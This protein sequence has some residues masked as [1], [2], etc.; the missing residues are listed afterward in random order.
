M[1]FLLAVVVLTALSPSRAATAQDAA[2]PLEIVEVIEVPGVGAED[3]FTRAETW[4]AETFVNSTAV[5]EVKDKEARRFI[6]NGVIPYRPT[7]PVMASAVGQVR[8]T[9][10]VEVKDGRA[11]LSLTNF[12]HE[13]DNANIG[14]LTEGEVGSNPMPGGWTQGLW[15]KLHADAKTQARTQT[16]D[17]VP[18][19]RAVLNKSAG[20]DDW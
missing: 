10:K 8:Y 12:T 15:R 16:K 20:N 3:L 17:F 2:E 9:I 13:G 1:R 14:R 5:L 7:N 6:G 11:R 4:F 19:L 18:S